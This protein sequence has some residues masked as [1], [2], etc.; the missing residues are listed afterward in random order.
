MPEVWPG[1][2]LNVMV[3][4]RPA[5]TFCELLQELSYKWKKPF[6]PVV[7][8]ALKLQIG[9]IL[10]PGQGSCWTCW[11]RRSRQH[12]D[13]SWPRSV[14]MQH[15]AQNAGDGPA[16][17]LEP[18]V[19]VAA[20]KLCQTID[21]VDF[22]SA[23]PGF[24]WQIDMLTRQITTG[25]VVGI[26]DCPRCGLHRPALT[27]SFAAMQQELSYLWAPQGEGAN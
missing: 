6:V 24:V 9:P 25:K 7:V 18:L 21:D 23:N 5:P 16:G 12:S 17:Y 10:I 22:S 4:W 26:H 8:E 2:R 3:S 1:S 19:M 15:Y 27:R 11:A 14:M 13:W 20:A